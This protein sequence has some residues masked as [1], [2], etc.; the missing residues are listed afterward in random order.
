MSDYPIHPEWLKT[1]HPFEAFPKIPRLHRPVIITEKID[2][3]NASITIVDGAQGE[4]HLFP[5]SRNRYL[6]LESDNYGFARWVKEH[7]EE[8]KQLGPGRHFGEW[9][10]QGIQRNYGMNRKVFSLFN[11]TRWE[12]RGATFKTVWPEYFPRP[13]N[14]IPAPECCSVVPVLDILPRFDCAW[15]ETILKVLEEEGSIV[16]PGFMNP[17]GIVACHFQSRSLF[18]YTLGG[19]G[20]KDGGG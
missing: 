19:D 13:E 9:W 4:R 7:E 20:H 12:D 6:T 3:T 5:A 15:I 16:A 17:E 11:V 1:E 2:G 8:L 14:L 10:G 18:K